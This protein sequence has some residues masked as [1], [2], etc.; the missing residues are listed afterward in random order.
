MTAVLKVR[1]GLQTGFVSETPTASHSAQIVQLQ[2]LP[3]IVDPGD[4]L[5]AQRIFLALCDVH[6]A[7]R[8][9]DLMLEQVGRGHVDEGRLRANRVCQMRHGASDDK[10]DRG[11]PTS[12]DGE[13]DGCAERT[14]GPRRRWETSRDRLPYVISPTAL[15]PG[16]AIRRPCALHDFSSPGHG[17]QHKEM[18]LISTISPCPRIKQGTISFDLDMALCVLFAALPVAWPRRSVRSKETSVTRGTRHLQKSYHPPH[19]ATTRPP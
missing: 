4:A 3:N 14:A 1:T 16:P 13:A 2:D 17:Q 18:L 7:Q 19:T 11:L 12:S 8:A 15:A 6:S 9:G 10:D 5:D